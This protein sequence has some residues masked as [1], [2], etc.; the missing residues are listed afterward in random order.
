MLLFVFFIGIATYINDIKGMRATGDQAPV[1]LS[2]SFG[3]WSKSI[4]RVID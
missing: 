4:T 3:N 2:D 1:H